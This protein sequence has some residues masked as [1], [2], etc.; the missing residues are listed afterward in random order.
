MT[1]QKTQNSTLLI[2]VCKN[3]SDQERTKRN[4][5]TSKTNVFNY[6]LLISLRVEQSFLETFPEDKNIIAHFRR[7]SKFPE[8]FFFVCFFQEEVLVIQTW[9]KLVQNKNGH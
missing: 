7:L 3:Y 2:P 4:I 6:T 1:H 8:T 5:W 9:N